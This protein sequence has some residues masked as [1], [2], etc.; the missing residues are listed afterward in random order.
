[1]ILLHSL[2]FPVPSKP[3]TYVLAYNTSSTTV[4]VAWG[5][6]PIGYVHGILQGYIIEYKQHNSSDP[7]KNVTVNN[8]ITTELTGLQKYTMYMVRVMA[9]TRMGRGPAVNTTV[10]TDEDGEHDSQRIF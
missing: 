5:E 9:F 2:S 10:L 1:M 6:V 7:W 8:T 3:P 4:V